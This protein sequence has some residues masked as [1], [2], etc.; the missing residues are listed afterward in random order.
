MSKTKEAIIETAIQVLSLDSSASLEDIA[1]AA[2]VSR[3]TI[4]RNFKNRDTLFHE[5]NE[6]LIQR[7]LHIFKKSKKNH[8]RSIDQLEEVIKTSANEK[9]YVLLIKENKDH[10]HHDPET[11]LFSEVS[12]ELE[13]L[14]KRLRQEGYLSQTIPDAWVFH[15]Y[16]AILFTAWEA[17]YSGT[18]AP[19]DIPTLSWHTFKNGVL[20]GKTI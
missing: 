16:D 5:I 12:N 11:C 9:G 2:G 6:T 18:V 14:I 13:E 4:H 8:E 7:T 1:T 15:M 20:N 17:L 10:K 3:M 19:N